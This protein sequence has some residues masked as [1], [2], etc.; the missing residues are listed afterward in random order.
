MEP[1]DTFSINE[2]AVAARH[3]GK[4]VFALQPVVLEGQPGDS[5]LMGSME[6]VNHMNAQY[7]TLLD[8]YCS[9]VP[10]GREPVWT[11]PTGMGKVLKTY[12]L[13]GTLCIRSYK[14]TCCTIDWQLDCGFGM[15]NQQTHNV[16]RSRHTLRLRK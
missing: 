13:E 3:N 4:D 7:L 14:R 9:D 2:C 15:V 12:M 11:C 8:A 6:D 1:G 16:N 10:C 5:C